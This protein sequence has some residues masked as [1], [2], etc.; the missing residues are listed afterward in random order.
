MLL[1]LFQLY[2]CHSYARAND[3]YTRTRICANNRC[4]CRHE[5]KGLMH[6]HPTLEQNGNALT[7][8]FIRIADQR[9]TTWAIGLNFFNQFEAIG[10]YN[11]ITIRKILS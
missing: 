11:A 10:N 8:L 4:R 7:P 5:R 3:Q 2:L 6:I 9:G 1:V